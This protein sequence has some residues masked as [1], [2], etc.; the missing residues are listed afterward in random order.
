MEISLEFPYEELIQEIPVLMVSGYNVIPQTVELNTPIKET[1]ISIPEMS[2]ETC[3]NLFNNILKI[4]LAFV[5]K[6]RIFLKIYNIL[7]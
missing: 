1:Q 3:P 2:L 7:G 6:G 4:K 5:Q